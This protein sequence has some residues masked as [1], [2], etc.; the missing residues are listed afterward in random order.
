MEPAERLD[1]IADILRRLAGL[2]VFQIGTIGEL[3]ILNSQLIG[4]EIRDGGA[5]PGFSR[6][7]FG[8]KPL[9]F[10]LALTWTTAAQV[11]ILAGES[12]H[13]SA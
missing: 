13:C 8:Q 9:V 7:K 3:E 2:A 11:V 1:R 6:E 4:S 12:D 5:G 10:G